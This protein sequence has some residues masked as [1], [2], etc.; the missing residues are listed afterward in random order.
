MSEVEVN[1]VILLFSKFKPTNIKYSIINYEN[2]KS[3]LVIFKIDK[4]K[5]YVEVF[6]DLLTEKAY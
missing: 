6:F 4:Y 5:F 3:T 1:S 2:L